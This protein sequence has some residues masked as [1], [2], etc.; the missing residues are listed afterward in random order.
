MG[1]VSILPA[2]LPAELEAEL[3]AITAA[4]PAIVH[5][6]ALPT[7]LHTQRVARASAIA[8]YEYAPQA[9]L[10]ILKEAAIRFGGWQIGVA[11]HLVD[12]SIS[13]PDGTSRSIKANVGMTA[14]GLRHSGASALLASYREVRGFEGF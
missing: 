10:E 6:A 8:V 5:A 7:D 1:D 4:L 12:K 9:P 11:P 3:A 2:V 14:S 13:F